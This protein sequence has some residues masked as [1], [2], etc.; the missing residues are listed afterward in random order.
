[1][2]ANG[3]D[4]IVVGGGSAG[5]VVASRLSEDSSRRVLL[6]EAGPDFPTQESLPGVLADAS[7]PTVDFDWGYASEPDRAA[8]PVGLPRA[9]VM[10][11]CSATNATF[12]LRGAPSDYDEWAKAG[13]DGWA[14]DDV[15]PFFCKLET[16][17][18]FDDAWHGREGPLPIRR[19]PRPEL[20]PQQAAFI[21]AA[22]ALGHEVVDDHNR[23]GAM[24]VGVTP[25]NA[26]DGVRISTALA[27]LA[28]ARARPNLDV[29][30][31]GSVDRVLV[32]NG[33]A[34]G[35][36]LGGGEEIAAECVVLSAGAYGSPA[37]LLRSGIGPAA[38]LTPLSID[39]VADLRGVGANLID[40]P[41]LSVD[42]PT[43]SATSGDWFQTALTWRST[44]CG[45]SDTYDMHVVGGGPVEHTPGDAVFFLF[46]GLMRP[47]S[48]GR[49]ALRSSDPAA[50]PRIHM[51]DLSHPDDLARM[52]E[53]IRLGRE[54][55]AT[56][57]LR[58]FVT[59]AELKPGRELTTST[60]LQEAIGRQIG[61]Y[62]HASGT[63]AM[64]VDP[65]AGS[66]VDSR[67]RVHG[68][69]GLYVADA[70]VM[71]NI[72]AAN[73]NLPAIMI[74]ERIAAFLQS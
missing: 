62:H 55:L 36:R 73:T 21:D 30:A 6:L 35:V 66:V 11:G 16:D 47:R 42:V 56:E 32:Q 37:I 23:P 34:S 3:Y 27:Y 72:P 53:G 40:H 64:G 46:V 12:A 28:S 33:R 29:R 69:D 18:D 48:R 8:G 17:L 4:A 51:G 65:D 60:E 44:R 67:G 52:V 20:R 50:A 68:I 26:V 1:V 22:R 10:G 59:G 49:V 7:C 13:N 61:V 63:C 57:P 41:A 70:S 58:S 71:P 9:K 31:N 74:G 15:L 14:F 38:H 24:G 43:A 19:T 45:G 25:R 39:P 54:L 5:A 2:T